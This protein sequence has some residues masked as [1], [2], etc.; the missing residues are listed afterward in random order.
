[1][2]QFKGDVKFT[3]SLIF[4]AKKPLDARQIVD[5]KADLTS[6]EFSTY[7]YKGLPVAVV[8]DTQENNGIYLLI[9]DNSTQEASW[10]KLATSQSVIDS[11]LVLVAGAG[12]N[13][14]NI[15]PDTHNQT[16]SV[17]IKAGA[18]LAT[19]TNDGVLVSGDLKYTA[20]TGKLSIIDSTGKEIGAGINLPLNQIINT[21]KSK[22]DPLTEELVLV[23]SDP[24]NEETE[25][26][27]PVVDLITEWVVR[28]TDS[29]T[30]K[31]TRVVNGK[32]ELTA[33]L[34][35]KTPD[36]SQ[37]PNAIKVDSGGVYVEDKTEDIE[38]IKNDIIQNEEVVAAALNDHEEK[39]N[40][41]LAGGAGEVDEKIKAAIDGL[42][43]GASSDGD[44]LGKLENLIKN[45]K[46]QDAENGQG[47]V[48]TVNPQSHR[49]K[50]D[51]KF[52]NSTIKLNSEGNL[53][54]DSIDGGTF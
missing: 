27:I 6:A 36:E 54:V 43:G 45:I 15:D 40:A 25:V 38:G 8:K 23:F 14:S 47:T 29:I 4:E 35:V 24:A 5:T 20:N 18:N 34:R 52:D 21:E 53:Y 13:L 26:R 44:T 41:L 30:L 2:A 16:V 42:K 37:K 32:D 51:V 31:R 50:I 17:K 49:V 48:A 22:Y 3:S 46:I 10:A 39:I 33:S 7:L 1:M 11:G 12:I 9:G 28:D 19:A